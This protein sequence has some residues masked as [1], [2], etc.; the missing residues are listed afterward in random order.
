MFGLLLCKFPK[1]SSNL[2]IIPPKFPY[3]C[4]NLRV[5]GFSGLKLASTSFYWRSLVYLNPHAVQSSNK[6]KQ[7][8]LPK[9]K[10]W[11]GFAV[12]GV[13]SKKYAQNA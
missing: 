1:Q 8:S 4:R 2:F 9:K 10:F 6:S 11:A 12:L 7:R 5:L 3:L 13:F